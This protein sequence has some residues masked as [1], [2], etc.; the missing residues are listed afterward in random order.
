MLE[1]AHKLVAD[2]EKFMPKHKVYCFDL[3][4]G[5]QKYT[6]HFEKRSV[7]LVEF[8]EAYSAGNFEL[9]PHRYAKFALEGLRQYTGCLDSGW[10]LG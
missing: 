6:N 7:T 5:S 3:G 2:M 9:E 8:N 1:F 10:L 4:Y